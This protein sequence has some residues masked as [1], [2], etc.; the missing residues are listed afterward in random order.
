MLEL[1]SREANKALFQ[2][3]DFNLF[4]GKSIPYPHFPITTS[5]SPSSRKWPQSDSGAISGHKL[6]PGEGNPGVRRQNSTNL[7]RQASPLVLAV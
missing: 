2:D 6:R 7:G 3:I 5:P 1:K 4:T